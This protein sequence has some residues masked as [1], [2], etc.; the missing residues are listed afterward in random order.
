MRL[1]LDTHILLVFVEGGAAGLPAAVAA[2]LR[3]A[4]FR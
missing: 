3:R 2:L 1:L 4:R